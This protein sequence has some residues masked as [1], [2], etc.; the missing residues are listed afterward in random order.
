MT[1]AELLERLLAYLRTEVPRP[2]PADLNAATDLRKDLR[3]AEED[4]EDLLAKLF[5][6]FGIDPGDFD[7][8]RYFPSEGLW[9]FG[10][11]KPGPVPLTVGMLAKAAVAG[12]WRTAAIEA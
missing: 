1:D 8:T 12:V 7:F 3:M 6:N 5:P 9:P 10:R 11:S 4:A 2:L